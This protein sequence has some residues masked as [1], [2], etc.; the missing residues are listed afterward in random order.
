MPQTY[1]MPNWKNQR[2]VAYNISFPPDVARLMDS[3]AAA[4]RRTRASIV[5]QAME[6]FLERVGAAATPE[7]RR[8]QAFDLASFAAEEQAEGSRG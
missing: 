1:A 4:S 6:E 7:K 2:H 5:V 8:E 3:F